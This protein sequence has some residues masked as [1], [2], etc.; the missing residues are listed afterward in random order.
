MSIQQSYDLTPVLPEQDH[1]PEW[2]FDSQLAVKQVYSPISEAITTPKLNF[3][4]EIRN[5]KI[6]QPRSTLVCQ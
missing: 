5:N 4:I 6:D 2:Q 3:Q 1:R